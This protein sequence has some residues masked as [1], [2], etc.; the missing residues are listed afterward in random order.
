[1]V[2]GWP[3]GFTVIVVVLFRAFVMVLRFRQEKTPT[4]L[5]RLRTPAEVWA[6]IDVFAARPVKGKG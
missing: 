6:G 3:W 2:S 5:V 4:P 1:M